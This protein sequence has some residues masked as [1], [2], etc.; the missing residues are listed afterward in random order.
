M[1]INGIELKP[2]QLYSAEDASKMLGLKVS[3]LASYRCQTGTIPYVKLGRRIMYRG[4][5]INAYIDAQ[6]TQPG[7]N[8]E[9]SKIARKAAMKRHAR[10]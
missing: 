7:A 6:F 2:E 4:A 10:A 9:R 5:D 3:T 8:P 1:I